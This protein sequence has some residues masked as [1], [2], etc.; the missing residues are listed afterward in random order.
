VPASAK[1]PAKRCKN[2]KDATSEDHTSVVL[3]INNEETQAHLLDNERSKGD[4]DAN[5][6]TVVPANK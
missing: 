4:Q 6:T 3:D 2:A 1:A 5:T